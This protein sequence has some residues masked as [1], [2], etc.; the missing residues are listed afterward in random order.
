MAVVEASVRI[1]A[2]LD[3]VWDIA[4]DLDAEP[5]FWKGTLSAR[6]ISRDGNRIT[7]EVVIAFRNKR[8]MQEVTLTPKSRIDVK[9]TEGIIVGSKT[10]TLEE[11]GDHVILGTRW[12]ITMRGVM[13]VFAGMIK[14]HIRG[15]TEGALRA[16]REKAEE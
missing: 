1:N 9:F 6:N 2:P 12:D 7:R 5:R 10:I 8:C 16:I 15:G 13:G 3:A 14:G 11:D 4:A